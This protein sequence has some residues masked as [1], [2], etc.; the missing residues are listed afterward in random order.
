MM[1]LYGFAFAPNPRKALT[2]LREKGIPFEYISVNIGASEHRQLGFTAK[3]PM[4]GLPILEL[5]DGTIL[6]ESM[7]IIEYLEELHPTPPMIGT[8]PI[9]RQRVRSMERLCEM[10][11]LL[12]VGRVFRNTHPMFASSDQMPAVAAQARAELPGVLDIVDRMVGSQ[13]FVAGETPTIADCTL[14]AAFRLAEASGVEMDATAKNLARWWT[15]FRARPSAQDP[16][17]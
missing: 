5:D 8:D 15:M 13:T 17:V 11:V 6:T 9:E 10:S 3:N 16:P 4:Q 2:Y 7:P 12:R 1:K 14:F